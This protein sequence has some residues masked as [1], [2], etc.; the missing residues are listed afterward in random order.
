MGDDAESDGEELIGI[1]E[2]ESYADRKSI[3]QI[4]E[5]RTNKVEVTCGLLWNFVLLNFFPF[6][7][8][9]LPLL[10]YVMVLRDV[11]ILI[12]S[13]PMVIRNTHFMHQSLKQDERQNSCDEGQR[14]LL[15]LE[16][17]WCICLG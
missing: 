14:H 15:I 2:V 17:S 7:S 8:L 10:C 5:E 11:R 4:V 9:Q 6:L 1:S 16:V 3:D 13:V 12:L